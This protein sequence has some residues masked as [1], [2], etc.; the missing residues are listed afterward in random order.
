MLLGG[1]EARREAGLIEEQPVRPLAYAVF[2]ALMESAMFITTA[3]DR[4]EARE[5]AG[6]AIDR[7]LGG[8]RAR[9]APSAGS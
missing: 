8:L 1:L 6:G 5:Q 9:G 4:A 3:P 2:G 7:L